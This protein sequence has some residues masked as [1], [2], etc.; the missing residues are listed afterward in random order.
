MYRDYIVVEG[1]FDGANAFEQSAVNEVEEWAH[2]SC[3]V[4]SKPAP[5]TPNSDSYL[6]FRSVCASNGYFPPLGKE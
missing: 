2:L 6:S 1:E 3:D 4:S 5:Q